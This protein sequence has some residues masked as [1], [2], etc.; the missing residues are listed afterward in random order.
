MGI[1]EGMAV[2]D[3]TY[4]SDNMRLKMSFAAILLMESLMIPR[5]RQ[6]LKDCQEGSVST[7]AVNRI[8]PMTG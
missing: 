7:V 6:N 1:E 4:L 8:Q 5:V 3:K 2:S